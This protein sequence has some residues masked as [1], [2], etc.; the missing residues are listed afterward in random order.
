[1]ESEPYMEIFAAFNLSKRLTDTAIRQLVVIVI[2]IRRMRGRVSV[3]P[4]VIVC[5]NEIMGSWDD[6]R[7]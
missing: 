6:I 4:Y 7:L 3:N 5:T 1:M 2:Y